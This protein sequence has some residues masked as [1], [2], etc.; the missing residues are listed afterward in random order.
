[1]KNLPILVSIIALIIAGAAM[2]SALKKSEAL[3][4]AGLVN[5]Q[6]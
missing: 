6:S 2:V 1:M 5:S 4:G 3:D